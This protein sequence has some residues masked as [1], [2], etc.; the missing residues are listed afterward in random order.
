MDHNGNSSIGLTEEEKKILNQMDVDEN[1][2]ITFLGE[3]ELGEVT[4]TLGPE[5]IPDNMSFTQLT[6]VDEA[7]GLTL[8]SKGDVAADQKKIFLKDGN[9]IQLSDGTKK[10]DVNLDNITDATTRT[11]TVLD[12]DM[13][14]VGL[15]NTQTLTNKS[16]NNDVDMLTNKITNVGNPTNAQDVATKNYCDNIAAG[17]NPIEPVRLTTVSTLLANSDISTVD[18]VGVD[19]IEA[20]LA[21]SGV[22]KVDNVQVNNGDRILIRSQTAKKENG[23]YTVVV[24]G[25]ECGLTRTTDMNSN[26]PVVYA[27]SSMYVEEGDT[28]GGAIFVLTTDEPISVS[29]T[30]GSDLDFVKFIAG[31]PY[32]QSLNTTNNVQFAQLDVDQIRLDNGN[33]IFTGTTGNNN[34]AMPDNQ[35]EAL[36]I[37]EGGNAYMVFD[38][39][40][41]TEKVNIYKELDMN[42]QKIINVVD[43]STDQGVATKKYVDDNIGGFDPFEVCRLATTVNLA[44]NSDVSSVDSV[45]ADTI[46]ITLNISAVI[47]VDGQQLVNGDRVLVKDQT[48]QRENGIYTV[49]IVTTTLTLTRGTDMDSSLL[50]LHSGTKVFVTDG[51]LQSKTMF[52]ITSPDTSNINGLTGDNIIF[53]YPNKNGL[54]VNGTNYIHN[55]PREFKEIAGKSI[56][57]NQSPSVVYTVKSCQMIL[58][59]GA[60]YAFLISACDSNTILCLD[61]IEIGVNG[62]DLS[63][64][65]SYDISPSASA[66]FSTSR[67]QAFGKYLICGAR[68]PSNGNHVI[69]V[70]VENPYDAQIYFSNDITLSNN[71]GAVLKVDDYIYSIHRDAATSLQQ[72]IH[73]IKFDVINTVVQLTDLPN[74]KLDITVNQNTVGYLYRISAN[75]LLMLLN[76]GKYQY[77]DITDRENPALIG[78]LTD[79]PIINTD[80]NVE[81]QDGV[82]DTTS[83]ILGIGVTGTDDGKLFLWDFTDN[84]PVHVWTSPYLGTGVERNPFQCCDVAYVCNQTSGNE[85]KMVSMLDGSVITSSTSIGSFSLFNGTY[86]GANILLSDRFTNNAPLLRVYKNN[87]L[88]YHQVSGGLGSFD[89]IHCNRAIKCNSSIFCNKD[90]SGSALNGDVVNTSLLNATNIN[91]GRAKMHTLANTTKGFEPAV[92]TYGDHGTTYDLLTGSSYASKTILQVFSRHN[93]IYTISTDLSDIILDVLDVRDPDNIILLEKDIKINVA[94]AATGNHHGCMSQQ[95]LFIISDSDDRISVVDISQEKAIVVNNTMASIGGDILSCYSIGSNLYVVHNDGGTIKFRSFEYQL[96]EAV[97]ITETNTPLTLTGFAIGT[98]TGIQEVNEFEVVVFQKDYYALISVADKENPTIVTAKT[99]FP[100]AGSTTECTPLLRN[101]PA[102]ADYGFVYLYFHDGLKADKLSCFNFQDTLNPVLQWDSA[103]YTNLQNPFIHGG[104]IYLCSNTVAGTS[105]KIINKYD[106]TEYNTLATLDGGIKYSYGCVSNGMLYL[107]N[108]DATK[109]YVEGYNI[110]SVYHNDMVASSLETDYLEANNAVVSANLNVEGTVASN[111]GHMA[112]LHITDRLLYKNSE[113]DLSLVGNGTY[114]NLNQV[115][116]I[117]SGSSDSYTCDTTPSNNLFTMNTSVNKGMTI[118]T[119][120]NAYIEVV[121]TGDYLVC[122]H[123]SVKLDNNDEFTVQV[124]D[125]TTSSTYGTTISHISSNKKQTTSMSSVINITAGKRLSI[126]SEKLLAAGTITV[127]SVNLFVRKM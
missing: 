109:P 31:V 46:I 58:S 45:T 80:T 21:V 9:H 14:L 56:N 120:A 125:S 52:V 38:T 6:A 117:G 81:F 73:V 49:N 122:Y 22:F 101:K 16:F 41:T 3:V 15:S 113:I 91:L 108:N 29:G 27:G 86:S 103:T 96:N 111:T 74:S 11:L 97:I 79:L 119:G 102:E 51:E 63:H 40:N 82:D 78:S 60:N 105:V 23:I 50:K 112:E 68:H 87:G 54:L 118:S 77:I 12:E 84:T 110:G 19:S 64:I 37:E 72:F 20:T 35:A 98:P 13:T 47:L 100:G 33:V 115:Y 36:S 7:N 25:T 75:R 48:T 104:Y 67:G 32:D 124:Y 76:V 28:C 126:T 85:A 70:D 53:G 107:V 83:K 92:P 26:T 18:S 1:G 4:V 93:T 34:L 44:A 116:T 55:P 65:E 43:P 71:L 8:Q 59:N 106:G 90:I 30:T 95:A 61:I 127:Y 123:A 88:A 69:V 62:V 99:T 39:T 89:N 57:F 17:L 114:A 42:T 5:D 2:K 121:E 94:A 66:Y 24:T 10:L